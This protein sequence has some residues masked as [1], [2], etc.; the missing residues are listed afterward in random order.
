M[1][2]GRDAGKTLF[3][4]RRSFNGSFVHN[5]QALFGKADGTA[6]KITPLLKAAAISSQAGDSIQLKFAHPSLFL[7]PTAGSLPLLAVHYPEAD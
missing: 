7:A 1:V 3:I 6:P 5:K 4:I 2:F